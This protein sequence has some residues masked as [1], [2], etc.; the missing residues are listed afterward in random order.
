LTCAAGNLDR[1]RLLAGELVE[2]LDLLDRVDAGQRL[3]AK[4]QKA[5][6]ELGRLD[7]HELV[8][9][10]LVRGDRLDDLEV[11]HGLV[12]PLEGAPEP[13]VDLARRVLDR[14]PGGIPLTLDGVRLGTQRVEEGTA[15]VRM[16]GFRHRS[17]G[18]TGGEGAR[19][20]LRTRAARARRLPVLWPCKRRAEL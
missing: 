3:A 12:E 10:E 11:G 1:Q 5:V 15:A 13:A 9:A 16:L 17:H 6:L 19:S 18:N 20:A 7:R 4:R 8:D 14:T 2:Q